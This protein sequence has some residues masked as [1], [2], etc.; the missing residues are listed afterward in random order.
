M[1]FMRACGADFE[2]MRTTEFFSAHE[3]LVLDYERP[4]TRV[5]SRTG[6]LYDTSGHFV[7]VGERTRDL[8]GAHI[9]F[10]AS[11]RNPVGV[12]VSAERRHRRPAA[13][14]RQDR[15]RARARPAHLHHPD[16]GRP[17]P[18]GAADHRREGHGI[19][20][21]GHLG[22]RPDARQHLRVGLGLQDPRLRRPG[23]GRARLSSPPARPAAPARI[24]E[25]TA[26]RPGAV[27]RDGEVQI[28]ESGA[29]VQYI[30]EKSEALLPRDPQGK[31]R[32]IQWT[33]AALN[34]VEPAILNLLLI[35]VFYAGEEWAKLRRPG[36]DR[37]RQ[38]EAQAR[39]RLARR[40]AVAGRRP[41]HHRRP[42]DGHR[43]ALP[44]SHR[45]RRRISQSRRLREARRSASGIPARAHRPARDVSRATEPE[46]AAA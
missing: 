3:A 14:H 20:C 30:G 6:D 22:L 37:F 5:D 38:A 28:F 29:I 1:K 24:S 19:R 11:V 2:A 16:G 46:G 9:D 39:V 36:A 35:D 44:P 15:P 8:D 31:Y 33:Y 21:V 18:R 26:V 13:H 7:W 25:R 12:K 27:L 10:V 34:S 4:M 23:R 43:A 17:H 41:L 45:A 40:Q 42:D 32:A